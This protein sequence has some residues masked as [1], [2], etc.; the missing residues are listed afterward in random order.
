MNKQEL[1][2]ISLWLVIAI[3]FLNSMAMKFHWYY[4]I[5]WFDMPM[6]LLGGVFVGLITLAFFP[7]QPILNIF[8]SILLIGTLWE[9]FEFSLDKFITYNPQNF[10]DTL[11]DLAYDLAGGFSA[12]LYF[13]YNHRKD[14]GK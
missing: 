12:S 13:L 14:E 8:L 7:R 11:S 5:W 1:L 10:L 6:H 2:K 3:F 4:S 9:L